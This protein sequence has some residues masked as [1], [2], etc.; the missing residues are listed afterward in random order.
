MKQ[1]NKFEM[2]VGITMGILSFSI[3]SCIS[4]DYYG[5]E[6]ISD[7][8]NTEY[9]DIIY[10]PELVAYMT[11]FYNY[12]KNDT[13]KSLTKNKELVLNEKGYLR[14]YFD[15]IDKYPEF[16]QMTSQDR[17][18][19]CNKCIDNSPDLRKLYGRKKITRTKGINPENN[20][21]WK[22]LA[23]TNNS[24]ITRAINCEYDFLYNNK[25]KI[26]VFENKTD[27]VSFATSCAMFGVNWENP[28]PEQFREVSGYIFNNSSVA[29][30]D[31]DATNQSMAFVMWA[32]G[33]YHPEVYFQIHPNAGFDASQL[34]Q[35]YD[36]MDSADKAAK[37]A[38]NNNNCSGYRIYNLNNEYVSF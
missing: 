2:I 9:Y 28:Q 30:V 3:T 38:V 12:V 35:S 27:A 10:S 21:A 14:R 7:S 25:V 8:N 32:W 17:I 15:L 26:I 19:V 20:T 23:D 24:N 4:D 34:P 5:I 33:I 13:A 6:Q 29:L 22:S 37:S 36:D 11:E 31:P 1:I 18:I 16:G